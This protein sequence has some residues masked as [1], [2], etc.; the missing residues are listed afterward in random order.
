MLQ[1]TLAGCLFVLSIPVFAQ[2]DRGTI[3]GTVADPAGAVVAAAPIEVKNA[4]TGNVYQGGSSATGNYVFQVPTGSYELTVTVPGF[5]KYLRQNI[6]VPVEQTVRIDVLLEVGSSAESV[7]VTESAPLLKTESGELSHNVSGDTLNSLPVLGIGTAAVGSTGIRSMW[8]VMNVIPGAYW[9]PDSAVRIN[10]TVSNMG[11]LRVEGQDATDTISRATTSQN[12]PSVEAIQ[13]FAIQTSNYA[14]EFGQAGA[15]LFNITM[16]SGTNQFHGSVYDYFVN[17][18]LNAGVPFT[19]S[20][21]GNL[22]RPKTRRNDYGFSLGGPVWI[23]KAYNG[24]D[25]TFFF[26]NW[27][28]FRETAVTNNVP[29]TVPTSLM[30]QGD[31]SQVLTGRKLGTDGLGRSIMENTIYDPSTARIVNGVTYTDPYLNN[32][33]PVQDLDPVALKVQSFIPPPT[34]SGLVNNYLPIYSNTRVSS[35]PSIKIDHSINARLKLSGY[36]SDT[37][38]SAPN[39]GALTYPLGS[40]PSTNIRSESTRINV[41]YTI[42]PTLLL[43]L[44]FGF[45][46]VYNHPQLKT[47]DPVAGLGFTGTYATPPLF[48]A[49]GGLSGAQG[50]LSVGAGVGGPFVVRNLKPTSTATLTWVHNNHTYKAGG[51]IIVNGSP[52]FGQGF[53]NGSITFLP[54]ET[55]LPSLGGVSRVVTTV[56]GGSVGYSYASFLIG[57]PDNGYI[58]VPA[59]QRLGSHALAGFVQDSWKI[60]RKLTIDY[61]LRYDFQ[62]Y[63]KEHNGYMLDVSLSTPNPAAG[64]QPGGIIFEGYG[65]GR[66]NCALAENYPYAFSPRFGL[67]YQITPKTVLRVGGGLSYAQTAD[68]FSTAGNTGSNKTFSAPSYGITPPFYLRNGMPYQITFPNFYAGQQ[69]LPGTVSAPTNYL[70]RHAGWPARVVQWS[71]GVQREITHNLVAEAAYVGNRGVWWPAYTLSWI[72]SDA[73][74]PATLQAFGLNLNNPADLQLLASPVNSALAA[75]R[76]FGSPYPGFPTGLS[77]AQALRPM[78]EYTMVVNHWNPLGNTWYDSLQTKLTKRFSHG[79]DATVS[80]TWSKNLTLGAEDNNAY[81]NSYPQDV[82]NRQIDKS[83]SS[84]SQPQLLIVSGNYTTP[85]VSFGSGFASKLASAVVKDWALGALL[86]YGSGLPIH[87]PTATSNLQTYVFQTAFV[88]RVPGVSPFTQD[89]NC[90][91]FDPSKTF[92]LNPAAWVNPP[93]GQF[94][95]AA[96]YYDDYRYQRRPVE[97]LSLGRNFPIKER[98]NLQIRAEFTNIFNRTEVN[99]PVSTNAFATQTRNAAGINTAGFGWVNTATTGLPRQGT[100]VAR[101]QF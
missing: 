75:Q 35:I 9:T 49:F 24:H 72:S 84:Y 95:T 70:D 14:A 6:T 34:S 11:A 16:K 2:S 64:G 21:H 30:R 88:N 3:T 26:F 17:E 33:I 66:C 98:A 7:T 91:C 63:L 69:P 32:A 90:H 65:G 20:G 86:K 18:D 36:W 58:S 50:G 47:Y 57:S 12:Q 54:T 13:E 71:I 97:N 48:P 46:D 23:P 15:G 51:E 96:V 73:I 52:S 31:F 77:V 5:K 92:V 87:V 56:G 89:L 101:F 53:A 43:H 62:T 1:R 40:G 83:L 27:E 29:I 45:L 68:E 38:T 10:G 8:S 94:G 61:G 67:A 55:A 80:Y 44:G 81:F 4:Q 39:N 99:N 76:G 85:K 79:L 28:Q 82:F 41:D 42:T 22:L 78:P 74:P 93:P 59:V 60:T 19:N 100:I 25:R 37:A